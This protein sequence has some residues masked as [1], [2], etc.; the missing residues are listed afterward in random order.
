[1]EIPKP[2]AFWDWPDWDLTM[3]IEHWKF[4]GWG[5][6]YVDV[7]WA[8]PWFL[9]IQIKAM[10]H[11]YHKVKLHHVQWN[12]W[13]QLFFILYLLS[14]NKLIKDKTLPM[15]IALL[16]ESCHQKLHLYVLVKW[17]THFSKPNIQ[18]STT[19]QFK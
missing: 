17:K 16:L 2:Q 8:I 18:H 14:K 1:M 3:N 11:N 4:C 15:V 9:I 10:Q 5:N 12:V 19:T 6:W 13:F 7:V